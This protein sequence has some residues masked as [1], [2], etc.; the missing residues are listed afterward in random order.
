LLKIVKV[1]AEI[2]PGQLTYF[3]SEEL[4]LLNAD[5]DFYS[6]PVTRIQEPTPKLITA[7]IETPAPVFKYKGGNQKYFLILT[8]YPGPE[9]IADA[10]LTA[11]TSTLGRL[12][13]ALD[14]TAIVNVNHY[15]DHTWLH[16]FEYFKPQK[17]MVL[18]KAALPND[19]PA[20]PLNEISETADGYRA[21]YTFSFEEMM[22]QKENTKLFWNQI[23]TL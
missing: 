10:H 13:F 20:L 18:G 1:K 15:P 23:K 6:Q 16:L 4:Y 11:L 7:P 5:K 8:H 14:D 17:L 19:M 3:L 22:G 12:N 9:F 21:L 2:L